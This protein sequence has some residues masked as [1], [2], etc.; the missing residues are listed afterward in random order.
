MA[1]TEI[2]QLENGKNGLVAAYMHRVQEP[3]EK[4]ESY[5]RNVLFISYSWF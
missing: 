1:Q 5:V 3:A 2:L 4:Y